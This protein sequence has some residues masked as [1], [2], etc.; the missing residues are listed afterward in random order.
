MR[1]EPCPTWNRE[2]PEQTLRP[3]LKKVKLWQ[4]E[5]QMC[6]PPS[7]IAKRL[8]EAIGGKA[9]SMIEHL[10]PEDIMAEDGYYRIMQM[11]EGGYRY[12]AETKLEKDVSS[13]PL[14]PAGTMPASGGGHQRL[15]GQRDLGG[16]LGLATTT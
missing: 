8:Y 3:W 6:L 10:S 2:K 5:A 4:E 1:C 15:T 16:K 9:A 13:G 7:I 14:H 11:M 12:L